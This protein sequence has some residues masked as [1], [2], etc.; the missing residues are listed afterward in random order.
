MNNLHVG[1]NAGEMITDQEG[2]ILVGNGTECYPFSHCIMI[3]QGLKAAYDYHLRVGGIDRKMT[4][5]EHELLHNTIKFTA[6]S[7][8]GIYEAKNP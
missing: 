5:E 7:I 6:D 2:C 3:G 4:V 8:I 1:L